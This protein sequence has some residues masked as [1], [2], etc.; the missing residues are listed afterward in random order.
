MGKHLELKEQLACI[1]Y[2]ADRL[3][4]TEKKDLRAV[5]KKVPPTPEPPTDSDEDEDDQ[6]ERQATQWEDDKG[7]VKE[8]AEVAEP[9]NKGKEVANPARDEH[10]EVTSLEIFAGYESLGK[11]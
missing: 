1:Y 3:T 11:I 8:V 4:S 2:M 6:P 7:K 5:S 10:V 9:S